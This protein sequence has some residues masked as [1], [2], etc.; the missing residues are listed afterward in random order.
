MAIIK[1]LKDKSGRQQIL[2]KTTTQA[3]YNPNG[4]TLQATLNR[5]DSDLASIKATG[6]TN[7]TGATITSGTYFYLNGVLVRAK[8][9]IDNGL[10]FTSGTNYE[11]VTAGALNELN[12]S[13]GKFVGTADIEIWDYSTYKRKYENVAK[14]YNIIPRVGNTLGVYYIY[15]NTLAADLSGINTMLQIKIPNYLKDDNYGTCVGGNLFVGSMTAAR[16]IQNSSVAIYPRPNII[17]TGSS[18]NLSFGIFVV[19]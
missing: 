8:E 10:T 3:V 14:A 19:M 11:T 12:D 6:T 16:T 17:G 15:I 2:P 9:D 1:Q 13:L 5:M 18:D 7:T 4:S